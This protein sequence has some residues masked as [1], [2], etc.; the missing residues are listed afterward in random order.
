[1]LRVYFCGTFGDNGTFTINWNDEDDVRKALSKDYRIDILDNNVDN[2]LK[3]NGDIVIKDLNIVYTG[4]YWTAK[5]KN[6]NELT[7]TNCMSLMS[8]EVNKINNSDLVICVLSNTPSIGSTCEFM[9]ALNKN[10]KCCLF[11]QYSND[12][13]DLSIKARHWW[14]VAYTRM[15]AKN[16]KD[17]VIIEY[18]DIEEVKNIIKTKELYDVWRPIH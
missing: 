5:D 8:D 3:D 11:Y 2:L 6:T 7:S 16:N 18:K 13:Y 15:M 14:I 10:K 12:C 1:M 9:Y 17:I 4:P